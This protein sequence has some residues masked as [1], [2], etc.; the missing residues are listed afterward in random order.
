MVNTGEVAMKSG[1][2]LIFRSFSIDILVKLRIPSTTLVSL[3]FLEFSI[4]KFVRGIFPMNS[5]IFRQE[6]HGELPWFQAMKANLEDSTSGERWNLWGFDHETWAFHGILMDI[7][8][9]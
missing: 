3:W 6:S 5:G 2:V 9:D 1:D 4:V 7:N 8:H